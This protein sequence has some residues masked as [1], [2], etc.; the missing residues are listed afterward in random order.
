MAGPVTSPVTTVL[1][2]F[3][4]SAPLLGG[5]FAPPA[6]PEDEHRNLGCVVG[7]VA[8]PTCCASATSERT[9]TGP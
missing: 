2:E 5:L 1:A 8:G 4:G 6:S 9:G 3:L 7:A